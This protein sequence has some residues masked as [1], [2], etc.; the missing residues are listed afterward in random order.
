MSDLNLYN[1]LSR[2]KQLFVP[3]DK[4]MFVCMSV[5]LQFMTI[6]MLEMQGL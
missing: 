5:D 1:T 6:L 2:N 4:K 3:L